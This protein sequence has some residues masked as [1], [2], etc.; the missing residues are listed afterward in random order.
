MHPSTR[1]V[2]IQ[3]S[4]ERKR[5]SLE[6]AFAIA[7]LCKDVQHKQRTIK[8]PGLTRKRRHWLQFV[9][10]CSQN[11]F[12]KAKHILDN[13]RQ[14]GKQSEVGTYNFSSPRELG[15]GLVV[16]QQLAARQR[17]GSRPGDK[18]TGNRNLSHIYPK[19]PNYLYV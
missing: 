1:L 15:Q 18:S 6:Y 2:S 3:D 5:I 10:K 12:G 17:R 4:A 7:M 8:H 13:L 16:E 14:W 9:S 19:E 11:F